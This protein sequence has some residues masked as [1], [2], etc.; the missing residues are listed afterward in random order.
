MDLLAKGR[1]LWDFDVTGEPI[2]LDDE[3][4]ISPEQ[5][6]G[7]I[8]V[9]HIPSPDILIYMHD[10][11]ALVAETG[12]VLCHAAVLALEIGCPIIVL[13]EGAQ[14]AVKNKK[15]IFLSCSNGEGHIYA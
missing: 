12:G 13:A 2:I 1:G 7:K 5:C 4:S 8:I 10:A 14:A 11:I 3:F 15:T 6:R 9:T